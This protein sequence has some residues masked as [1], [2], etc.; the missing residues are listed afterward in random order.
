MWKRL[1]YL[2]LILAVGSSV[3]TGIPLYSGEQGCSM[4][5]DMDCC[6]KAFAERETPEVAAARLCCATNCSESAVTTPATTSHVQSQVPSAA[7]FPVAALRIQNHQLP[8][9]STPSPPNNLQRPYLFN[10]ALLI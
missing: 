3:A 8:T 4:G 5:G 1:T 10:L 7:E 6:K 2:L 9:Y